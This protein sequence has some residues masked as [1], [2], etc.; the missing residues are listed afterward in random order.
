MIYCFLN[1]SFVLENLDICK[2]QEM[3]NNNYM[4]IF[5]SF[6]AQCTAMRVFI[7]LLSIDIILD[8]F[9][10][11]S[12][13]P[14]DNSEISVRDRSWDTTHS[15]ET[16]FWDQI[17]STITVD[18]LIQ[19]LRHVTSPRLPKSVKIWCM[20]IK[21]CSRSWCH[22][23]LSRILL[24]SLFFQTYIWLYYC[25]PSVSFFITNTV[26]FLNDAVVVNYM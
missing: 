14:C 16:V 4:L 7:T 12:G 9:P 1:L 21:Q 23:F 6:R 2:I 11:I 3:W 10:S 8:L 25:F 26:L 5:K 24:I 15:T 20:H 19:G 13:V 17:L 22:H 18:A